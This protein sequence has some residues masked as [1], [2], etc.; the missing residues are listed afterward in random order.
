M[1]PSG[2]SAVPGAQPGLVAA[3]FD[4]WVPALKFAASRSIDQLNHSLAS[5]IPGSLW[6][7]FS[8]F[9][10]A[11]GAVAEDALLGGVGLAVEPDR[12]AVP[13]PVG[14]TAALVS[15]P[16]ASV[17]TSVPRGEDAAGD[18]GT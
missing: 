11:D 16:T 13:G 3:V 1:V 17:V 8:R 7:Q 2:L 15:E 5:S 12:V 10:Y 9:R 18:P 14:A 4:T 6:Q